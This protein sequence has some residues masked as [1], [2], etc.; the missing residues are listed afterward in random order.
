MERAP[1]QGGKGAFQRTRKD[2]RD[3][4]GHGKS[5]SLPAVGAGGQPLATLAPPRGAGLW[6][7]AGITLQNL[8]QQPAPSPRHP[9]DAPSGGSCGPREWGQIGL[10][11]GRGGWPCQS[12]SHIGRAG[13]ARTKPPSPAGQS[14]PPLCAPASTAAAP[15]GPSPTGSLG[16]AW[17][18][19]PAGPRSA[20]C[21]RLPASVTARDRHPEA[22]ASFPGL[23]QRPCPSGGGLPPC[24]SQAASSPFPLTGRSAF[25]YHGAENPRA[26]GLDCTFLL[27]RRCSLFSLEFQIASSPRS[28]HCHPPSSPAGAPSH[29]PSPWVCFLFPEAPFLE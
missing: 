6:P 9:G 21:P 29:P 25:S 8:L 27:T 28:V 15:S 16:Q 17:P 10:Q 18:P 7:R 19:A 3:G 14:H 4:A 5:R 23:E 22:A 20:H 24:L 13:F 1:A 11:G 12:G 2:K 26:G